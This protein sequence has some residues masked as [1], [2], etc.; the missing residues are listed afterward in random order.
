MKNVAAGANPMALRKGM[1]AAATAAVDGIIKNSKK[2]DGTDDI[3]RVATVSSSDEVVGKLIA[4]A[5]EK[6]TADAL[7]PWR[8]P[9][10]RRPTLKW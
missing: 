7:S 4:D 9:K 8:S 1:K 3:A 10:R 6:V 2:V 5:M